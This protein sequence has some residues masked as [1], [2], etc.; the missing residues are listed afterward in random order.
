MI[1]KWHFWDFWRKVRCHNETG[2]SCGKLLVLARY[3]SRPVA[4]GFVVR[5]NDRQVIA[6]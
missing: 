4:R 1:P 6:S 5:V 2:G 3:G